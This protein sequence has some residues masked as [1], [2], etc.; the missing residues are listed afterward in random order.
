MLSW[1]LWSDDNNAWENAVSFGDSYTI[2]IPEWFDSINSNLV[3]NKEITNRVLL[4]YKKDNEDL[5]D[6]NIV[7]TLSEVWPDLD[8]EQFWTVNS[9]RLQTSLA[10]YIPGEQQ[11]VSFDCKGEN[12]QG[13]Y[14]TFDVKNTFSDIQELTYLSQYQ[15]VHNDIGYIV[16]FASVN[17]KDRN[18]SD[19]RLSEISCL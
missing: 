12:V 10:W 3:E 2:E 4:S 7:V 17:E 14:V 1:C 6:D 5:F 15:Y 11:R 16:S 19:A 18:K 13:L 9:K 8:Y